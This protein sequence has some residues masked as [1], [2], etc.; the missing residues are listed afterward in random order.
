[1][2]TPPKSWSPVLRILFLFH[3]ADLH[4]VFAPPLLW[5]ATQLHWLELSHNIHSPHRSVLQEASF[6]ILFFSLI[7][8]GN[9]YFHFHWYSFQPTI[10]KA[11]FQYANSPLLTLMLPLEFPL[12]LILLNSTK[13]LHSPWILAF[14]FCFIFIVN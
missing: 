10:P 11:T 2:W 8:I 13:L 4:L 6:T 9:L 5:A 14:L 12:F 1:M 3:T 7:S